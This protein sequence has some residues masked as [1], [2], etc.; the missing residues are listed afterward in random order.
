V[1][2]RGG[3]R[4]KLANGTGGGAGDQP[5]NFVGGERSHGDPLG[6]ICCLSITITL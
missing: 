3:V 1:K 2:K 5:E 4:N 6:P